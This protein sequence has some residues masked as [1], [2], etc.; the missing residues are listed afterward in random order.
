[1]PALDRIHILFLLYSGAHNVINAFTRAE[2]VVF[3]VFVVVGILS[4]E[5]ML[6]AVYN[7]W[8]DGRLIGPMQSLSLVAGGVAMFYA[9]AGILAQAQAGGEVSG[10]L[11]MYY[12]WVLPTSAP[13]M[14]VF[15]F[16]IQSV[17][18]IANAERRASELAELTA[19]DE[20]VEA[21]EQRRLELDYRRGL[22]Q[23]KAGAQRE[24]LS[25]LWGEA[26]SRRVRKAFKLSARVE[27]PRILK[28]MGVRTPATSERRLFGLRAPDTYRLL[29]QTTPAAGADPGQGDGQTDGMPEVDTVGK[30]RGR[31]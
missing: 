30:Q 12:A 18:P 6:W 29:E 7:H 26:L 13:V 22:R 17:D 3:F 28:L 1:M 4:V 14:F 10:W 25:A 21:T 16:L 8:K 20:G 23:L 11:S 31:A 15:A 2:N 5:L 24:R 9:T 27:M 19:I